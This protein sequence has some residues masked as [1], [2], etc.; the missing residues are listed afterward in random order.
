MFFVWSRITAE[1]I[2][3]AL[4]TQLSGSLVFLDRA[5]LSIVQNNSFLLSCVVG[6]DRTG[7]TLS[8]IKAFMILF[9]VL[10][11]FSAACCSS[12]SALVRGPLSSPSSPRY[13]VANNMK[14]A[15]K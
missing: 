15:G 9:R 5:Y 1:V 2:R 12:P 10:R 4:C 6:T 11:S 14:N 8:L 13:L 7:N 3:T